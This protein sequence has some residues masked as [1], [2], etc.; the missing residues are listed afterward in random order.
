LAASLRNVVQV[1]WSFASTR[2]QSI[3]RQTLQRAIDTTERR[4]LLI[5]GSCGLQLAVRAWP[6]L[7]IPAALEVRIVALGPACFGRL[8]LAPA[9]ITVLQGGHDGWSRLF[10]RGPVDARLP[11]GHLDYWTSPEVREIVAKLLRASA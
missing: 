11:C 5:T 6:D 4:L 3:V 9:A 1:F 2:Y 8:R 10:Y 7:R